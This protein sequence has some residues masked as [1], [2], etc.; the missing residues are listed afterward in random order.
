LEDVCVAATHHRIASIPP[1][2]STHQE[3]FLPTL[4]DDVHLP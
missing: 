1:G 3:D 4:N 2:I